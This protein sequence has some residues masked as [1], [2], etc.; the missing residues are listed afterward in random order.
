MFTNVCYQEEAK[1]KD[2]TL[3][4]LSWVAPWHRLLGTD[5]G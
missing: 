4:P 5:A 1:E 3:V 2:Q